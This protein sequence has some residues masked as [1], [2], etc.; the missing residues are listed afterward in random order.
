MAFTH[1]D[2][3]YD[4]VHYVPDMIRLGLLTEDVFT[5]AYGSVQDWQNRMIREG[6]YTDEIF[7][8]TAVELLGR[9]V[10]LYPV[11]PTGRIDRVTIS[12]SYS[13]TYDPYHMLYF[14][15]TIFVNPH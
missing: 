7:I 2:L 14:D 1:H 15:E 4:V 11:I 9:Q 12:P 10:I 13:T 5:S 8:Q 3:R 6:T